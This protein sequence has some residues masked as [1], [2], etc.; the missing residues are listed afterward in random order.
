MSISRFNHIRRSD[1][2]SSDMYCQLLSTDE[3]AVIAEI[4]EAIAS[5]DDNLRY[6]SGTR[7]N[8]FEFF[9]EYEE[10]FRSAVYFDR[11]HKKL[12]DFQ[13]LCEI[14]HEANVEACKENNFGFEAG[15]SCE[16]KKQNIIEKPD[17]KSCV[18]SSVNL[19]PWHFQIAKTINK[20]LFQLQHTHSEQ[21]DKII[22]AIETLKY[23]FDDFIVRNMAEYIVE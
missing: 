18:R 9:E 15:N 7:D 12:F 23:S 3:I 11:F 2:K 16:F 21:N 14:L 10:A 20:Y 13:K 5:H 19:K 4:I 1:F 8:F 17:F 6:G 22:A